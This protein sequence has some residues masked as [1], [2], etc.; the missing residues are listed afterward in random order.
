MGSRVASKPRHVIMIQ[1]QTPY[2]ASFDLEGSLGNMPIGA[3]AV[4]PQPTRLEEYLLG[5]KR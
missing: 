1:Y 5:V 4:P 3:S 2:A